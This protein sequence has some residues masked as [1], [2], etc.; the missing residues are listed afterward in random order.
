MRP[1]P[2]GPGA[3]TGQSWA[4]TYR[5][6]AMHR[7]AS[8][9]H[10]S[11]SRRRSP[12]GARGRS[13]ADWSR[14]RRCARPHGADVPAPS[15]IAAPAGRGQ[16]RASE[17]VAET[18]V[19][20]RDGRPDA[21]GSSRHSRHP[22]CKTT[23]RP[24]APLESRRPRVDERHAAPPPGRSRAGGAVPAARCDDPAPLVR[25]DRRAGA[26]ARPR[27]SEAVTRAFGVSSRRGSSA[28]P[29]AVGGAG[30]RTQ[31]TPAAPASSTAASDR[32][33]GDLGA[34][35]DAA[36]LRRRAPRA[37]PARHRAPI[38]P[39]GA[40]ADRDLVL[41][42]RVD[43]DQRDPGGVVRRAGRRRRRRPPR[44][45]APRGP[46]AGLVV[47][48]RADQEHVAPGPRRGDR[49]VGALAAAEAPAARRRPPSRPARAGA[50]G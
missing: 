35:Q 33:V 32:L 8:P 40:G 21:A 43:D 23:E 18:P 25:P 24:A 48:D 7:T 14:R 2:T 38:A 4:P 16:H 34:D 3:R 10:G 31:R 44:P 27:R 41:A 5:G 46:G 20:S 15:A 13:T 29:P 37:P 19:V 22:R 36:E 1:G 9:R 42:R 30:L 47:A 39:V 50:R 12:T 49:G 6:C 17:R 26:S 45:A 11:P 28:R